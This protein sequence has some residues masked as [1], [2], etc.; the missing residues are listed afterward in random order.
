MANSMGSVLL[1]VDVGADFSDNGNEPVQLV[2][3]AEPVRETR[4]V[5]GVRLAPN[6][7]EAEESVIG[8]AL[9]DPESLMF[10]LAPILKPEHFFIVKNAWV[11]EAMLALYERREPIDFLIVCHELETRNRLEEIGGAAYISHLINVVPT[12]IHG[13]G[14]AEIV[15]KTSLRRGL[16]GAAS[17]IAQLAYDETEA[18]MNTLSARAVSKLRDVVDSGVNLH[19]S[20]Q[21]S[22]SVCNDLLDDIAFYHEHPLAD[23]EVRGISTGMSD[24]NDI[25]GGLQRG[26]LDVIAGRTGL[27]KSTL[28]FQIGFNVAVLKQRVLIASLE[29]KAKAVYL[30]RVCADLGIHRDKIFG[31]HL[32][33]EE[34]ARVVAHISVLSDLP[35][36]IDDSRGM[37]TAMLERIVAERGPFD[38][39]EID[40][41]GLLTD[42]NPGGITDAK[43]IGNMCKAIRRIGYDYNHATLMACQINRGVE[44]RN[45][46]RPILRDLRDSGEIEENAD[47]VSFLYKEDLYDEQTDRKN[48]A[49][50]ICRKKREGSKKDMVELYHDRW[51]TRFLSPGF[52]TVN[53]NAPDQKT[54]VASSGD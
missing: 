41:L 24:L 29:M 26:E 2:V 1:D 10:R 4:Q 19:N 46:K 6:A 34:Y 17:D 23:G 33:E 53:L 37:T 31:G 43:H 52:R 21:L 35:I 5:E 25:F 39:V 12:A 14:Y 18:D 51:H 36:V 45:D 11:W 50:L 3:R 40:H 49:E 44:N 27:G 28:L 30:R 38:L 22:A 8:S 13:M 54:H 20:T 9:I 47:S 15:L 48:I 7:I 32:D 16:L 42:K